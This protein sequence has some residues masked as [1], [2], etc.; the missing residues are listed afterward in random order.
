MLLTDLSPNVD[1]SPPRWGSYLTL[2]LEHVLPHC[3]AS[4]KLC[5]LSPT[6]TLLS[7]IPRPFS[8]NF[9]VWPGAKMSP[10]RKLHTRKK[11]YKTQKKFKM[12]SNG[13]LLSVKEVYSD[14]SE[15]LVATLFRVI[16]FGSVGRWSSHPE[17]ECNTFLRNIF[18]SLH[19]A[20]K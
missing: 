2:S 14:V 4:R 18:G 11:K 13:L 3:G 1:D 15:R 9:Q 5:N 16:E 12:L 20:V 7:A 8:F 10:L 6:P 17:E 19:Y